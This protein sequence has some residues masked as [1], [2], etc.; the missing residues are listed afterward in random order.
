MPR[1]FEAWFALAVALTA[2]VFS[3]YDPRVTWSLAA[4]AT[5]MFGAYVAWN[6]KTK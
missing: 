3:A 6:R 1:H 5:A 4:A 2:L